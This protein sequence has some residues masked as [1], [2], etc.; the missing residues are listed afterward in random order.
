MRL[1]VYTDNMKREKDAETEKHICNLT[2]EWLQNEVNS[3]QF[4][5]PYMKNK[6]AD[7]NKRINIM[8]LPYYNYIYE[9]AKIP[10]LDNFVWEYLGWYRN[11]VP[12]GEKIQIWDKYGKLLVCTRQELYDR[13]YIAYTA[14]MRELQLMI[15]MNE[16]GIDAYYDSSADL[17]GIDVVCNINNTLCGIASFAATSKGVKYKKA[18]NIYHDK[19]YDNILMVDAPTVLG[20]ASTVQ[21]EN[22]IYLYDESF[23]DGIAEMVRSKIRRNA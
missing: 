10:T 1:W 3:I 21:L 17:D 19:I 11:P 4:V 9:N 7:L 6:N 22:G 23:V 13:L 15:G 5:R 12:E 16:R 20:G 14:Y 2:S 8:C 18:K